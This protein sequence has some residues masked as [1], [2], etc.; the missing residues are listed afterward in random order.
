MIESRLWVEETKERRSPAKSIPVLYVYGWMDDNVTL[1]SMSMYKR[2]ANVRKKPATHASK[3]ER[4]EG[5]AETANGRP[6]RRVHIYTYKNT[7]RVLSRISFIELV[8]LSPSRSPFSYIHT[9]S[10]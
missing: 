4:G 5:D 1:R 2:H 10:H 9:H 3:E 6:G 8:F 7:H